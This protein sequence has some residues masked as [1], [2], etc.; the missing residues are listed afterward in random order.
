MN[1]GQAGWQIAST[2]FCVGSQFP[3]VRRVAAIADFC[4]CG[5][6]PPQSSY[7]SPGKR[8]NVCIV[9]YIESLQQRFMLEQTGSEAK[10]KSSLS[11]SPCKMN[12]VKPYAYLRDL[13]IGIANGQSAK[14][15]EGMIL[16]A[17]TQRLIPSK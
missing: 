4:E 12:G 3:P 5:P 6:V 15:I 8:A 11:S 16:W 2:P 13:F 7:Q 10:R 17:Y 1:S 14:D 9:A